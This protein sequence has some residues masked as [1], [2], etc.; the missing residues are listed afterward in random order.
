MIPHRTSSISD[1][2]TSSAQETPQTGAPRRLLPAARPQPAESSTHYQTA[3]LARKRAQTPLAC[4]A[5]RQKKVKC[6]GAR[7]VCSQCRA[8][9][10]ECVYRGTPVSDYRDKYEA[11]LES[12]P[13]AV[14]YRAIQTRPRTEA[15]EIVRRIQAGVDAETLMRQFSSADLLLQVQLEPETRSRYQFI[16]SPLMPMY[17][18]T[19]D[20]PFMKSLIHEWSTRDDIVSIASPDFTKTDLG[21][22]AQ[23]LRPHH[24][25][26]IIDSRLDEIVPSKWTTVDVSDNTMRELIRAYFLQEY[27]WFTFFLK[28]YFLDDMVNGSNTFCSSLLVNAVL[29]VGCQCQNYVNEPAKYWNPNSLGY[30]FFEE[31]RRLWIVEVTHNR[32][33]TTLQ[34]AL[35][36]NT[37]VNM[38]D[39]DHLSSAFLVR[40]IEIAHGLG[41]FEPT[42]YIMNKKL[43][44]SYDL[45]AWSLF[46]WQCTLSYQFMTQP[47]L[48]APPKT[49]LPDP[50][51]DPDWFGEIWL[52][53]PSSSTLAPLNIGLVFEAKM[54]FSV[55][56]NEAMLE[57]QEDSTDSYLLQNG[58]KKIIEITKR[59]D[60]WYKSMPEPLSPTKIVS[61][62]QLKIHLHYCYVIIQLY[63][64][65]APGGQRQAPNLPEEEHLQTNLSKYRGYF[66][67]I[68][69]IHYLRHSFEY[70]NMMLTR[71]LAMLAF[72]SLNKIESL[73][74]CTEPGH[75]M[76]GSGLDVGDTDPKEV[77][78]TL[79]I[80]QKGLSDTGRG[81][82]LPRTLLRDVLVNMTASD[83]TIL[84]SF[85]TIPPEG[86][87][88]MQERKMYMES[89][90]PPDI[91][92]IANDPNKQPDGN[93]IQRFAMLTLGE[94]SGRSILGMISGGRE[95]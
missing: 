62:S 69:R 26:T 78:A 48:K 19:D 75:I 85:I 40:S 73:T 9:K 76:T 71:F 87:E 61:P 90:C 68:L 15:L 84:Q 82:Y 43:R 12:H 21:C 52:K 92:R 86:P 36:L 72:L 88:K 60:A 11:L 94:N 5:C 55:V 67:T 54:N 23:Y 53:Y 91:L 45:T 64:I 27:D 22:R 2:S 70:G 58:G 46:H 35:V 33:L 74:T 20:N 66:E 38:F 83:V 81:Y 93:W 29:A 47:L 28:D 25:A 59:L 24:A 39:M 77:R 6:N 51:R 4:E 89:H 37:I 10:S 7:P 3:P 8:W 95:S 49:P 30:K 56:L 18:Q 31:A 57:I 32:S 14:V 80:A 13:A 34:A 41:L 42:T 17:L 16:Y 1:A 50:D 44:N 63:E 65:L 79:L